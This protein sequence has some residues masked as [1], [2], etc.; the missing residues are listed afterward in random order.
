MARSVAVGGL[1]LS[2]ATKHQLWRTFS[3]QSVSAYRYRLYPDRVEHGRSHS[4]LFRAA[5]GKGSGLDQTAR[6]RVCPRA[7]ARGGAR[8][9]R[10]KCVRTFSITGVSKIA[11]MIFSSPPQF[12]Q[13]SRSRLKTRLSKRAQLATGWCAQIASPV[14]GGAAWAGSGSLGTTCARI[15]AFGATLPEVQEKLLVYGLEVA[16]PITAEQFGELMRMA[17]EQWIGI[18]KNSGISPD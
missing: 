15:V 14:S 18:K 2:L 13:C 5:R 16:A 7:G 10:P 3:A 17:R 9:S 8:A 6:S 1:R 11:A 12:G 4:P